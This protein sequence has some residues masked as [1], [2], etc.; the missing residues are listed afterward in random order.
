M[1]TFCE[2]GIILKKQILGQKAV[3]LCGDWITELKSQNKDSEIK[4][5]K[6]DLDHLACIVYSSGTTGKPKGQF[7]VV[8]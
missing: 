3:R 1:L 7:R 2:Y 6:T 5:P 4:R 8:L